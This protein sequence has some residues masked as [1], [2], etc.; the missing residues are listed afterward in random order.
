MTSS[1]PLLEFDPNRK[2][3]VNPI[4]PALSRP[5]SE[6][7]VLCFFKEVLDRLAAEG[8]LTQIG[9]LRSE[10]GYN[11]IY[12]LIHND[13]HLLVVH[14]GV[15]APLSAAILEEVI[16]LG[17]QTFM[18]CGG[19]GVLDGAIAAGH[20][21]VLSSALRDEGTSYHYLPPARLVEAD[22]DATAALEAVLTEQGIPYLIGTSWTTD[23]LFRETCARREERMREG[24]LVV[25]MEAAA[26]FAV[27]KFR[28]VRLG[29]IVYGGDLV[30]PDGW[31][32]R[33]WDLRVDDRER[34]FWLA[35]EACCKVR[36]L[37]TEH[38]EHTEM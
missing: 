18:V 19:C 21:V 8:R 30:L 32:R 37:T 31:D 7:G 1:I 28:G 24:C 38:T 11:P 17:T 15:G 35:V 33:G 4:A 10:I 34:L 26:L 36:D 29:Q 9:R 23:G 12:E 16:P 5:A 25:E 3:I 13:T 20:P 14:P 22:T 27:A 2:A 6:R